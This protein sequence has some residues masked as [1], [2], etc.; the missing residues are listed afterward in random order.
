MN[1]SVIFAIAGGVCVAIAALLL[2]EYFQVREMGEQVKSTQLKIE[3]TLK[4]YGQFTAFHYSSQFIT[5]SSSSSS[6]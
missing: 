3:E 5:Y 4:S 2:I 6:V 1:R